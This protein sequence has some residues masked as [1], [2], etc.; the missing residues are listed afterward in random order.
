MYTKRKPTQ[1]SLCPFQ[2]HGQL[3][4]VIFLFAALW[5]WQSKAITKVLMSIYISASTK[6]WHIYPQKQE[7]THLRPNPY[8]LD[9]ENNYRSDRPA[10]PSYHTIIPQF[11]ICF[12][13]W[14]RCCDVQVKPAC[15][16]C[17]TESL[18]ERWWPAHQASL[19][20]LINVAPLPRWVD[21]QYETM[22]WAGQLGF[23]SWASSD[24]WIISSHLSL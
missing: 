18:Q 7:N 24:E 16:G 9:V 2:H 8:F 14:I 6:F 3:H 15:V 13:V 23:V 5:N 1:T 10:W 20:A 22:W 12:D 21:L 19:K 11:L 17:H 4:S